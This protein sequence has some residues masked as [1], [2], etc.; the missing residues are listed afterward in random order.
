VEIKVSLH[1]LDYDRALGDLLELDTIIVT[2]AKLI[3]LGELNNTL[4]IVTADRGHG[5]DVFG[6]A[7]TKY[8]SAQTSDMDRRNVRH[9]P[10]YN[11][12]IF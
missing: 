6:S 4:I 11:F 8:L 10:L 12:S 7:D 2:I 9:S 1:T 3:A 5:F